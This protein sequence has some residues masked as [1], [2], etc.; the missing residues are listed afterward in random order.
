MSNYSS[1]KTEIKNYIRARIPLIIIETSERERAERMLSAIGNELSADIYYYTDTTQ[2][3]RL[4]GAGERVDVSGDP[5]PYISGLFAKKRNV[6][7]CYGDVGKIGED[8]V[9]S[10]EI[11]NA[12]YSAVRSNSTLILITKDPVFSKIAQFGMIAK[13]D[14]PDLGERMEQINSFVSQFKSLYTVEWD[15]SD[16]VVAATLLSGFSEI[17]INNILSNEISSKGGL[18][19][20]EI[21][22]LTAQKSKLYGTVPNIQQVNVPNDMTASG[23]ENLKQ[24]LKEK[25]PVFFATDDKLSRYSLSAPK[26]ILLSGV[27]GCGKSFSAKLIAKEW[28]LPLFRFDIGSVYDKWMGESER[29]MKEALD[30]IDNV[31]P[32]ILWIDEI[33]KA[34]SVSHGEN[35]TGKR[36]LGQFLFWLQ[37]STSRVFLVATA[38]DVFQLPAELFRKGRFSEVFFVDLPNADERRQAIKLYSERCLHVSLN[39]E[40][41][42]ELVRLSD[43]FSYSEIEYAIK[44][45]AQ[46]VF[47]NG[48]DSLNMQAFRDRFSLVVPIEK[49]RPETVSK[50]REWGRQRAVP[51]YKDDRG[52]K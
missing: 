39:A 22:R 21:P 42:D 24:W 17:Q 38:N 45:I 29:K 41:L 25:E 33:E 4:S 13:L 15:D 36:I 10:R 8:T 19:K 46:L 48:E 43:G 30:F 6:I 14:Y 49:S 5:V 9:Y 11:I 40:D 26:G 35:D 32:C 28:G 18:Y 7:F 2:V 37:E 47:V 34:L 23:L 27:P 20:A 31:A 16:V 1:T 3:T 50:I 44:E 12:L 52:E 51:A